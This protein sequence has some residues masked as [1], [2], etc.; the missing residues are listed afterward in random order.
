ALQDRHWRATIADW[1]V[2][3]RA[4]VLALDAA[5]GGDFAAASPATQ[6]D[7]LTQDGTGFRDL[8]FDHAIEGWLGDPVYG[9]NAGSTGWTEVAFPGD[10]C[11]DGYPTEQVEQGDGPDPID[12]SGAV[13]A[14]LTLLEGTFGA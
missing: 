2:R 7:V 14:L 4:G 13:G 3:F 5:A 6:D 11:P 10:A 9:G 12:P 1:Q 8:L